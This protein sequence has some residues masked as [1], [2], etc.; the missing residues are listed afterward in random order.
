MAVGR[1]NDIEVTPLEW[2]R[3]GGQ[4]HRWEL[5]L[6]MVVSMSVLVASFGASMHH[7]ERREYLYCRKREGELHGDGGNRL[8]SNGASCCFVTAI[9]SFVNL[10]MLS[11]SAGAV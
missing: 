11:W 4:R 3:W 9:Y 1:M 6:G 7:T 5:P 8:E 2:A 10:L